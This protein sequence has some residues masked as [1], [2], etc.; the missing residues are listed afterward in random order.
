MGSIESL[1]EIPQSV[2]DMPKEEKT[3]KFNIAYCASWGGPTQAD[4]AKKVISTVYPNA[5]IKVTPDGPL[6]NIVISSEKKQL[7]DAQADGYIGY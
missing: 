4:Y 2:I 7:Y 6:Y 3:V 5:S 1:N